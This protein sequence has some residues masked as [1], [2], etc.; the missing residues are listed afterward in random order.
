MQAAGPYAR[1]PPIPCSSCAAFL[2]VGVLIGIRTSTPPPVTVGRL[3]GDATPA[4]SVAGSSCSPGP[5]RSPRQLHT[6]PSALSTPPSSL[7]SPFSLSPLCNT[8]PHE[9]QQYL[10]LAHNILA[11]GGR[12][13][14][15]KG[16]GARAVFAPA[17]L[18]FALSRPSDPM[19]PFLLP[20]RV[21]P[22][23]TTKRVSFEAAREELVW[24]VHGRTNAS[25]LRSKIWDANSS[26]AYLDARA[27]YRGMRADYTGEGVDQL[28]RLV[29]SIQDEPE[30]RK[31]IL[32]AW[33]VADLDKMPL[34]PCPLLVQF[35]VHS[36]PAFP[37][38]PPTA[39]RLSCAVDQ[40]S[41]DVALGLPF[42]LAV[43]A[44]LAH[45]VAH[46][47]GSVAT[48]ITF[49]L[50]D[51]HVYDDHVDGLRTQLAREPCAPFPSVGMA[52]TREEFEAAGGV[53]AVSED[54]VV[55]GENIRMGVRRAPP[56]WAPPLV[57]F[58][59]AALPPLPQITDAALRTT[60]TTHKS[61]YLG[62]EPWDSCAHRAAEKG[63][64]RRLEWIR[65]ACLHWLVSWALQK[66]YPTAVSGALTVAREKVIAN[67]TLSHIS[68][69][70]GLPDALRTGSRGSSSS[71]V[72]LGQKI[73][74]DALEAH[75]GAVLAESVAAK[76]LDPLCCPVL[77][78]WA[79]A[80]VTSDVFATLDDVVDRANKT[81]FAQ[82]V[83][84]KRPISATTT[85]ETWR[86]DD[87]HRGPEGWTS[88]MWLNGHKVAVGAGRKKF[89]ARVAA[90]A[91]M[92][93]RITAAG[94]AGDLDDLLGTLEESE[95]EAS[96]PLANT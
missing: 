71:S 32:C 8:R 36:P 38:G 25:Q 49:F 2:L 35:Y 83:P 5:S 59:V 48:Q 64:N 58:D 30:K 14:T 10:D 33:N 37:L 81:F 86:Y 93:T 61:V 24:M 45:L 90:Y 70:Y 95:G 11:H 46:L 3:P 26:R 94:K 34:P 73:A 22:L 6:P 91:S 56:D 20:E 39:P 67:A 29:R 63:S 47:T 87:K 80:L 43:H 18:R 82:N 1:S 52:R 96:S 50:G 41:A 9:E 27:V 88:T 4:S 66:N 51:A 53:G 75:I 79:E 62:G 68:L 60:A 31:H 12:R 89:E 57:S 44:L 74:A 40:R 28:E 13:P 92:I 69:A 85:E 84:A 21:I 65:D 23:L 7:G 54:D 55:L 17:Q 78:D 72:Y 16:I 76:S 42:D 15:A 77:L 19:D